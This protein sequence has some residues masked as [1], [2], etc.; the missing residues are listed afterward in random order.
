MPE[1]YKVPGDA[2][3]AYRQFYLAEKMGFAKWTRRNLPYWVPA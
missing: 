2:V 3:T 1:Q